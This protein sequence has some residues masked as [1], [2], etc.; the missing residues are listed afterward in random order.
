MLQYTVAFHPY[1]LNVL[2]I[3]ICYRMKNQIKRFILKGQLLRHIPS[4]DFNVVLFPF[5]DDPLTF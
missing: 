4:N 5:R 2:N 3:T 1:W